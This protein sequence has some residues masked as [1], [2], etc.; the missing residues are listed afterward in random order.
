MKYCNEPIQCKLQVPG[1]KEKINIRKS[2]P[3][4]GKNRHCFEERSR[5]WGGY[6]NIFRG[7]PV[8]TYEWTLQSLMQQK[9]ILFSYSC[10]K[11]L[12][13]VY[14]CRRHPNVSSNVQQSRLA[15]IQCD[16]EKEFFLPRT[17]LDMIRLKG[18][19]ESRGT[20]LVSKILTRQQPQLWYICRSP[21]NNNVSSRPF[22]C[23][24]CVCWAPD[25]PL[26]LDLRTSNAVELSGIEQ[27]N[28]NN[29]YTNE[30]RKKQ[31]ILMPYFSLSLATRRTT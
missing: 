1:A 11:Y 21:Y 14:V 9:I 20:H 25:P 29:T 31:W 23:F 18:N 3:N 4:G 24:L 6:K 28:N 30:E 26:P 19:N 2:T 13:R 10:K 22:F 16:I 12:N 15:A 17:I 8:N 27:N 5:P 7:A